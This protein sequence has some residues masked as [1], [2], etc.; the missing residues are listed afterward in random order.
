MLWRV[1]KYVVLVLVAGAALSLAWL[2]WEAGR[3]RDSWFV[4]RQG[5]VAG[6][7]VMED[8]AMGAQLAQAVRLRSTSGLEVSFRVIRPLATAEPLPVF[9]VLGGHRTGSD[10]VDLFGEV[11]D[12]AVVGI[13][14]PYDG[15]DRVKGVGPV[16]RTIPAARQAFL[17]TVPAVSLVLDWL[18]DQPW[19]DGDRTI[20]IG[21][22]LGA[23]FA[24]T[25][26]RR[27]DRLAGLV[28]VHAAADNRRWLEVQLARRMESSL[29]TYPL[30]YV[31]HWLA[32]GPVFD[33]GEHVAHLSPRPLLIINARNDERTPSD[34][35]QR[36]YDAAGM[37]KKLRYSNGRHV[38]PGRSEIIGELLAIA[39]E[40]TP[41]LV[42]GM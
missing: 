19:A 5:S 41:F 8:V 2:R 13:D 23:P 28:L 21:A 29:V 24:A 9:V 16:L 11:G 31:L 12:R 14:Y 10:A 32:Y 30:S 34:E 6:A 26:A 38:Q 37:P 18:S 22:S 20:M 42:N 36:L 3:P 17:D 7:E 4:E 15:P 39:D 25:V 33:T 1:T 27:D 35:G 40:E